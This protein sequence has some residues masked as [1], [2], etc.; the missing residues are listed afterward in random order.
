M[1]VQCLPLLGAHVQSYALPVHFCGAIASYSIA[2]DIV[3]TYPHTMRLVH[4]DP[5]W[6]MDTKISLALVERIADV[7]L[8]AY[9][10]LETAL[11]CF[12]AL[13]YRPMA[14]ASTP[15]CMATLWLRA[16]ARVC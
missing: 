2:H 6:S 13:G 1:Q 15:C 4:I 12:I 8:T 5:D 16:D 10:G 14:R 11:R 9:L 7:H 3:L